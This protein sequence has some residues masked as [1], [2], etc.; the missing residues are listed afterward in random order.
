MND[1]KK[2]LSTL[3]ELIETCEDGRKGYQDASEHIEN[4]EL[5]TVLYRL[6]QQRA[7]FEAELKD[8][9]RHLGG[10]TEEDSSVAGTAHRVWLNIKST[11]R[12]NDTD[13]ILNECKRGDKAAIERYE[14][15]LKAELPDFIRE[16]VADQFKLIKGAYNQ[17][18]EF[19]EH[20][21]S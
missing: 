6:S 1:T 7:L 21:E 12:G 16:K 3:H 13:A 10:S 14:A 11:L 20:P 2:S 9:I 19:Q 18:V 8:E 15:A 4:E 5:K 17:L